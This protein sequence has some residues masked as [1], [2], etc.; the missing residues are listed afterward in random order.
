MGS[1]SFHVV[2]FYH[3]IKF[4]IGYENNCAFQYVIGPVVFE[5]QGKLQPEKLKK[6]S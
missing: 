1:I 4:F 2:K 6:L 5:K 3:S